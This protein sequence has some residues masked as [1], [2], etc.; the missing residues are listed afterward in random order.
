MCVMSWLYIYYYLFI[1]SKACNLQRIVKFAHNRHFFFQIQ[2]KFKTP[3]IYY[4]VRINA[5]SYIIL[6]SD[7]S[8]DSASSSH[9]S[10]KLF[11]LTNRAFNFQTN[12][13][14]MFLTTRNFVTTNPHRMSVVRISSRLEHAYIT[15]NHRSTKKD[16]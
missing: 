9:E 10:R 15:T 2:K 6:L 4:H 12:W 13:N 14:W 16:L 8:S 3:Y 11:G 5:P 1:V 7:T